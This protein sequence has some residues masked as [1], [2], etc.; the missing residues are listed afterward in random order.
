[1]RC[2]S[3]FRAPFP[4]T[5]RRHPLIWRLE[6]RAPR[7]VRADDMSCVSVP[8]RHPRLD[9]RTRLLHIRP[10]GVLRRQRGV[11]VRRL[12]VRIALLLAII[13]LVLTAAVTPSGSAPATCPL[14][15]QLPGGR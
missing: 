3:A 6:E 1:M 7:V 2:D 4:W 12:P 15:P 8:T 11:P 5:A 14:G 10:E 9:S 13:L